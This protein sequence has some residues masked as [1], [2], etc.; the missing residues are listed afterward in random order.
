MQPVPTMIEW[1]TL[2]VSVVDQVDPA[3]RHPPTRPLT[4]SS[5]AHCGLASV[6]ETYAWV[7]A[8]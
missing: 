7:Q 4:K 2:S 3:V 6:L 8:R 5:C 1:T